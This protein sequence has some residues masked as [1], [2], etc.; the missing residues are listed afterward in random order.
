MTY[1]EE[2][3]NNADKVLSHPTGQYLATRCA[4]CSGYKRDVLCGP[5]R[6]LFRGTTKFCYCPSTAPTVVLAPAEVEKLLAL[7][8]NLVAA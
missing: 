6:A 2:T 7:S 4:V 3:E 1:Q 8:A 5:H